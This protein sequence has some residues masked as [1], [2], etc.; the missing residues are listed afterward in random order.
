MIDELVPF[1][2]GV[3]HEIAF[4]GGTVE[5]VA[6]DVSHRWVQRSTGETVYVF[7]PAGGSYPAGIWSTASEAGTWIELHGAKGMLSKYELG[8][9]AYETAVSS[10]LFKPTVSDQETNAFITR[11]TSAID[12]WHHVEE[13]DT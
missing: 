12:H 10:G 8:A 11:F 1:D 4:E 9:S 13:T 2:G 3:L 5:I 6:D 7:T